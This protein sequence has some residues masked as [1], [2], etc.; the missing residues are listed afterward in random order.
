[1]ILF[2]R[3]MPVVFCAY[4]KERSPKSDCAPSLRKN[5]KVPLPSFF[6]HRSR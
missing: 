1:M 2:H 4:Q 5:P 6:T 3:H